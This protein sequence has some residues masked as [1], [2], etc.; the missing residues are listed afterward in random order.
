MNKKEFKKIQNEID[1]WNKFKEDIK[2]KINIISVDNYDE[3]SIIFRVL[4][5]TKKKDKDS[6]IKF[7]SAQQ[8]NTFIETFNAMQEYENKDYIEI[9]K[10]PSLENI[11]GMIQDRIKSHKEMIEFN[12]KEFVKH[13]KQLQGEKDYKKIQDL[14]SEIF[15]DEHHIKDY[16]N[17]IKKYEDILRQLK[18]DIKNSK[19]GGKR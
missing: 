13:T 4:K 15:W 2:E 14:N 18:H 12:K 9:T 3:D 1:Y 11:F 6:I 16:N 8:E 19:R 17:E 5:I 10:I 7:I